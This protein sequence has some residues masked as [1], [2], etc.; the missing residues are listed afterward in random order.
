MV[1]YIYCDCGKVIDEYETKCHWCGSPK[2][3][4]DAQMSKII[5]WADLYSLLSDKANKLEN[6]GKFNWQQEI[7]VLVNENELVFGD[8]ALHNSCCSLKNTLS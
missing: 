3:K 1:E 8:K 6:I 4:E 2:N 7:A 5:T